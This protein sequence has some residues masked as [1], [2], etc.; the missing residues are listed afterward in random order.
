MLATDNR[1]PRATVRLPA[2]LADYACARTLVCCKPPWRVYLGPHEDHVLIGRVSQAGD[3][4]LTARVRA[5][6]ERP[7]PGV[8]LLAQPDDGCPLLDEDA[9][10]CVVHRVAGMGALP[11][12]CRN[13]PRSV[14]RTPD[15][16]EVAFLLQCPTAAGIVARR[17]APFTWVE[18]DAAAWPYDDRRA[19]DRD[20][21]W[22]HRTPLTYEALTE[23]RAAWWARLGAD[24]EAAPSP[25][26]LLALHDAPQHPTASAHATSLAAAEP[27]ELLTS[28]EQRFLDRLD[29]RGETYRLRADDVAAALAAPPT[30][31][32]LARA[33]AAA[34]HAYLCAAA[35]ALQHAGVHTRQPVHD[36]LRGA[37]WQ[38]LEAVQLT[39]RLLP[40]AI[41]DPL[42]AV[43]D[44]LCVAAHVSRWL[45]HAARA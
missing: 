16:L 9:A 29:A 22:D 25:E 6:I 41:G 23:L 37:A 10:G 2:V 31:A 27:D 8:T 4:R 39:A 3:R 24:G 26:P 18:R 43:Q 7:A 14:V 13:F 12:T 30:D 19:A 36:V 33:W 17:P 15:G 34:P 40:L 21:W 1:A 11:A 32:E 44:G 45:A 42:D 35:L 5:A 38:T 20:L 28:A